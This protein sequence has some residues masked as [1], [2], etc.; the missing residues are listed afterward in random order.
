[1]AY[2]HRAHGE[3]EGEFG[4]FG[5][6]ESADIIQAQILLKEKSNLSDKQIGWVGASWGASAILQANL[7]EVK[8]LFILADSP[9]KDLHTAVMERAIRDYG[10]WINALVPTIYWIVRIRAEFD[11]YETSA[12]ETAKVIDVPTLLIHSQTDEATASSQSV[13]I[14][15]VMNPEILTFHHTDWGSLHCKD[16]QDE[17]E[18][19]GQLIEQFLTENELL[20]PSLEDSTVNT[21]LPIY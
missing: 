21:D 16:V 20:Q 1:M 9:F 15:E 6:M 4:T 12:L 17:P 11:P 13:A 8:P 18:K 7:E 19:Y 5:V 3:S 2:D 14:A 10:E